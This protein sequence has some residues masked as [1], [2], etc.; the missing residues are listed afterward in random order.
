VAPP[1]GGWTRRR[2][3]PYAYRPGRNP[4]PRRDPR[5]HSHGRPE[6]APRRF[7]PA[8]WRENADYLYGLDL[9]HAG[10]WWESHEQFEA[11]WRG[12]GRRSP[13][14][15]LLRALLL[16][17]GAELKRAIGEA[18]GASR[19]ASRARAVLAELPH[20]LLGVRTDALERALARG[21]TP[22]RIP[23]THRPQLDPEGQQV[24]ERH[25]D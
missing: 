21:R 24:R 1:A 6:P 12:F 15:R 14:A 16:V 23:M 8:A 2:L 19:L 22:L 9:F 18:A 20:P 3:P 4:H 5:G 10:Y 13:E 11:L 7:D 25:P 17:A